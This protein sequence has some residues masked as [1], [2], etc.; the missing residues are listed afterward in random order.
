MAEVLWL[1][2]SHLGEGWEPFAA[3]LRASRSLRALWGAPR[4]SA[5]PSREL[6]LFQGQA[7]HP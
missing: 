7:A 2:C 5:G 3:G 6:R 1:A 4:R